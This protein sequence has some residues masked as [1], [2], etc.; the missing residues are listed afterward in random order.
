ML[1]G[2][3]MPISMMP[4]KT[5]APIGH[6]TRMWPSATVPCTNMY[7]K[8]QDIGRSFTRVWDP[9]FDSR[10]LKF[11]LHRMGQSPF[12]GSSIPRLSSLAEPI[13]F[14]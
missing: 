5:V 2:K 14:K 4:I 13:S 3:M 9:K 10:K 11:M 7:K 6:D 1:F 8:S 12:L